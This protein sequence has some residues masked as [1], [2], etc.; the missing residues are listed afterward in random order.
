M[1]DYTKNLMTFAGASKKFVLKKSRILRKIP[2]LE[3][4]FNAVAGL[5]PATEFKK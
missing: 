5:R 2:V 1:K 4:L 3:S